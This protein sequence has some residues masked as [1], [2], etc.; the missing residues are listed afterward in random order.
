MSQVSIQTLEPQTDGQGEGSLP[1]Q[2]LQADVV[3]VGAAMSGAVL[4][5]SLAA[6]P[7]GNGQALKIVLIEANV[8]ANDVSN[9]AHA[10]FDARAIALSAGSCDALTRRGLWP[11]FAPYAQ[12]ISDIH[13]SDRG[14]LGQT[15][16]TAK[17]YQLAALGQ[18]IELASV[19]AQLQQKVAQH[20]QIVLRC[21]VQIQ[22]IERRQNSVLIQLD[23]GEHWQSR[24]LVAADGAHSYVR[25]QAKMAVHR[26]DFLQSAIIA[27][28]KTQQHPHGRAFE[29]FTEEGP[30]ALLPMQQGLSSLVW[31]VAS[32]RQATLMSLSDEAFCKALQQAF[33]WRLGR[34]EQVGPRHTYPLILTQVDYPLAHRTLL[35]GNAAHALH[36]IAGQGFNLA[37]RDVDVLVATLADALA[38]GEDIGQ[39]RVLN[40]YWQQRSDDQQQTVWLTSTLARLFANE[41]WPLVVG[42]NLGLDAM[43]RC[44]GLKA[45]LARRTLGFVGELT[46]PLIHQ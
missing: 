15:N 10:G 1:S 28:I 16:L 5:L 37:M 2:V 11:L 43:A 33:G 20:Q 38:Q 22:A 17:E 14:H 8:Q 39:F 34:I 35:I 45:R 27:T 40:R 7:Q 12:V 29:R 42:R 19:G 23:N 18:V 36:P 31:S 32:S 4:A 41:Y 9:A 44:G 30:L 46:D 6:L 3:I 24:L 13:V 26:H 25:Q 21:P